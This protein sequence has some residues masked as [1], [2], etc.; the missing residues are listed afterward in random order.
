MDSDTR[1][2]VEDVIKETNRDA[3]EDKRAE[4]EAAR[5][6]GIEPSDSD[7]YDKKFG[8]SATS[9][10]FETRK[11]KDVEYTANRIGVHNTLN[12]LLH[13]NSFQSLTQSS[14][15]LDSLIGASVSTE[16]SDNDTEY[17]KKLSEKVAEEA[18]ESDHE[19]KKREALKE[20]IERVKK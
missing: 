10:D 17:L 3:D 1:D 20:A 14:S 16:I 8:E 11:D 7:E 15:G 9:E 18:D 4:A 5:D 13:K 6:L 19:A 12:D 2:S